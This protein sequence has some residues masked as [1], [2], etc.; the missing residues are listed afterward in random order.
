M[1]HPWSVSVLLALAA[2]AGSAAGARPVQA[3]IE[4][5]PFSTGET[6]TFSPRGGPMGPWPTAPETAAG[7]Q[8]RRGL[9]AWP[10]DE[11]SAARCPSGQVTK[12]SLQRRAVA[13][14]VAAREFQGGPGNA[15]ELTFSSICRTDRSSRTPVIIQVNSRTSLIRPCC[16]AARNAVASGL[17]PI[18]S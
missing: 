6:V 13:W 18:R 3:Q 11:Y 15:A 10:I 4:A 2:L 14:L 5:L 16:C 8:H 12:M 9:A 7:G 1:R 17:A